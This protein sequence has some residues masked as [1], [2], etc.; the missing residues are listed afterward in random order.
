MSQTRKCL[1]GFI[2]RK[3]YTRRFGT[4]IRQK[5]YTVHRGSKTFRAYPT[6]A[7]TTVKSACV[8]D[9]GL[10]GKGPKIFGNLKQGDLMKYGYV[11]RKAEHIRHAALR[12]A[13]KAYGKLK[14]FH[15]LDA[16]AKLS[17]RTAPDASKVFRAD[18]NWVRKTFINV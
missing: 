8:K 6:A 10:P 3:H 11:Y 16:V 18:A 9:R 15:K 14:L 12:K 4:S 13:E 5:G 2:L 7:E 1:P 17:S